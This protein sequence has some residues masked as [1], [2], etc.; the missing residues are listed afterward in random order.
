MSLPTNHAYPARLTLPAPAKLNLFL[1]ITGQRADGYH[2]LQT[3]FRLIDLADTLEFTLDTTGKLTCTGLDIAASDNLILK[4]AQLLKVYSGS[5]FGA[6][7]HMEKILPI[8]GGIGGGSSN[9]ATTLLGLNA[10]WNIGLTL[11]ELAKLGL[12]LGADVPVFIYGQNAWAEGVGEQ[13]T[14]VILPQTDY[15]LL[16][17]ACFV[18]TKAVFMNKH[19]TRTTQLSTFAAYQSQ[20]QLFVND[21]EPVVCR[22]YPAVAQALSYLK[23]FGSARLTGTGACVFLPL[24]D[25]QD[26][27]TILSRAP[28]EGWLCHGL[29]RSPVH[30]LL[31]MA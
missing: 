16:K 15:I 11:H 20:P 31:F 22:L 7:I 23:Q 27:S 8:G 17:P 18:S 30:D 25:G 5:S 21:C 4:A 6:A 26:A 29:S 14:P 28:C 13:L 19:L 24:T 9:A 1:H 2:L 3:L 12:Q 10:L